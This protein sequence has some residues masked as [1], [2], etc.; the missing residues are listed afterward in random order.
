MPVTKPLPKKNASYASNRLSTSIPE[1]WSLHG[2]RLRSQNPALNGSPAQP[3]KKNSTNTALSRDSSPVDAPPRSDSDSEDDAAGSSKDKR[4]IYSDFSGHSKEGFTGNK[5]RNTQRNHGPENTPT[6]SQSSS[7]YSTHALSPQNSDHLNKRDRDG[8]LDAWAME[9]QHP[10][11]KRRM[12]GP[13]YGFQS[14][15]RPPSVSR[16]GP[17]PSLKDE[18]PIFRAPLLP[19]LGAE[20]KQDQPAFKSALVSTPEVRCRTRS[21]AQERADPTFQKRELDTTLLNKLDKGEQVGGDIFKARD[22]EKLI[23]GLP[24]NSSISS[25]STTT[26]T[27][28]APQIFDEDINST[29][30]SPLSTPPQSP[31]LITPEWDDDN[32]LPLTKCPICRK[33]VP[34]ADLEA[35]AIGLDS[36]R[37]DIHS[38]QKFCA[39]HTTSD[40]QSIYSSRGY[41]QFTPESWAFLARERIPSHFPHLSRTISGETPSYYRTML[42]RVDTAGSKAQMRSFL[43]DLTIDI[44]PPP[45][46]I[47]SPAADSAGSQG[48]GD[49]VGVGVRHTVTPGYYGPRGRAIMASTLVERFSPDLN[50]LAARDPLV[51]RIGVAGYVQTVLVPELAVRLVVEDRRKDGVGLLRLGEEELLGDEEAEAR[52]ILEESAEVGEKVNAEEEGEGEVV[53]V[54][55]DVR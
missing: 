1:E 39:Q 49:G 7:S 22:V 40:A 44:P 19:E 13:V 50:A 38:Q 21:G 48:D 5:R 11:K 25:L 16:R 53:D 29:I 33:H 6:K 54:E 41:P 34:L 27:F 42:D 37:L 47:P 10:S 24:P 51:K 15:F 35:F 20:K 55:R 45:T 14:K 46:T 18:E 36:R 12:N 9:T 4:F 8:Q 31:D 2:N 26:S 32:S 43:R 23:Q 52:R 30:A 28:S 17:K 3:L